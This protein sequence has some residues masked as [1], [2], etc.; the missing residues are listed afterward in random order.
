MIVL[1]AAALLV[2]AQLCATFLVLLVGLLF[3][4]HRAKVERKQ[5]RQ[6]QALL[7]SLDQKGL[8]IATPDPLTGHLVKSKLRPHLVLEALDA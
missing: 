6:G 3:T 7:K 2:G 5:K 4:V 8:S 1:S